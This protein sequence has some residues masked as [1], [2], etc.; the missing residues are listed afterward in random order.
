MRQEHRSMNVFKE[1]VRSWAAALL[2]GL[3]IGVAG[4]W[5]SFKLLVA[6][7]LDSMGQTGWDWIVGT[8][9]FWVIGT[10]IWKILGVLNGP[11]AARALER[12]NEAL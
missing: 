6:R 9:V 2:G 1:R 10:L 3:L 11:R 4:S 8:L 7:L 12:D 5:G